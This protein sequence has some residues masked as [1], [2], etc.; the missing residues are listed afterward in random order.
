MPKRILIIVSSFEIGGT[1][2]SLHSM[3]KAIDPNRINVDVFARKREGPY[4]EKLE[5][6]HILNESYWLTENF[7]AESTL[8]MSKVKLIKA[9]KTLF[10]YFNID[11]KDLFIKY[12]CKQLG[13]ECYDAIVSFQENITK[14]IASYPAK[15]RI[16]WIHSDYSRFLKLRGI[17]NESSIYA[18]IDKVVCV[19]EYSKSIFDEIYPQFS[20]KS[21]A[22]HNVI[23]VYGIRER[24]KAINDLDPLFDTSVFTI[25]SVGRLDPVKQFEKIPS[26]AKQ[27]KG[28]SDKPFKWYIIGG[29]RGFEEVEKELQDMINEY[30]LN[31]CVIR[32]G[33]KQNIYPYIAKANL[34]V[35]TSLSES[36]PLVVN[37]AKA[38]NIPVISNNFP[39]VR[40]SI[41]DGIDGYVVPL[42]SMASKIVDLMNNRHSIQAYNIDNEEIV[43]KL[44]NLF[45]DNDGR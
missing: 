10:R 14:E 28:L 38:L 7:S 17:N 42:G 36:F 24:A 27:I 25:V 43:N 23:D 6:C 34:Y 18:N 2:V 22:I 5:N 15:R 37:E 30:S 8:I 45:E 29:S 4:L 35:C 13:T 44:Y 9:I 26:I 41:H 33:E 11:V 21:V 3:L 1:I 20:G 16:A 19:S 12:G 40:E 32:L 31:D 39:S